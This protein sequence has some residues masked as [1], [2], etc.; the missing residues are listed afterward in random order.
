MYLVKDIKTGEIVFYFGLSAGLLYKEIGSGDFQ[1]SNLEKEIVNTCIS[2]ILEKDGSITTDDV[3]SWY[4]DDDTVDKEKVVRIIDDNVKIKLAARDDPENTEN[5]VNIKQ[6]SKTFPGIVV[7]HFC[8][9]TN[10][11]F[12]ENISFPIGFYVFWE[13]V[14]EKVLEIASLLGCQYLYLFAADNTEQVPTQ[15]SFLYPGDWDEDES[16]IN[17]SPV[18]KLV[19]YYKNELKFDDVQD[20]TILKPY[21]DF[22]CFSLIQEINDLQEHREAAWIQHSDVGM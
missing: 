12:T 10:Y 2:A 4:E 18:Y 15:Q 21:Y 5:V 9:N 6:V 19:E 7:T 14:I 3:L 13:I 20:V 1:L 22:Q 8:K 16:E 11:R 17:T